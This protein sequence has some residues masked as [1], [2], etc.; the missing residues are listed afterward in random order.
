MAKNELQSVLRKLSPFFEDNMLSITASTYSKLLNT[1]RNGAGIWLRNLEEA[2]YLKSQPQSSTHKLK[3]ADITQDL[4]H[5]SKND[6]D[7][8]LDLHRVYWKERLHTSNYVN[9]IRR[10]YEP[11]QILLVGKTLEG[12][13]GKDTSLEIGLFGGKPFEGSRKFDERLKRSVRFSYVSAQDLENL[14]SLYSI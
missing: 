6:T 9:N 8:F 2:G 12:E 4:L 13:L 11:A 3:N 14:S 7:L 5:Y 1:S 10:F